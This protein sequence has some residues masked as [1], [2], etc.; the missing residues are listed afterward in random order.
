M[1]RPALVLTAGLGTR[2][3]P[4]TR[5]VAKPAVPVSGRTLIER[6]LDGLAHQGVHDVVLNLHHLPE[7]IT[8]IVGDG[9]QHGLRVRYSWESPVLGSAGGPRHALPLLAADEF[10]IVNG[11]TLCDVDLSALGAAHGASGADVT[12]AVVPNPA[13]DRYNALEVNEDDCVTGVVMKGSGRPGWHFVGLQIARASV[14]EALPDNVAAESVHG[15]YQGLLGNRGGIRVFKVSAPF[16]DVGT[17]LDYL[18]GAVALAGG[19]SAIEPDARVDS[20]ARVT[21]SIVWPAATVG[22]G[23]TLEDCI[24]TNVN[25]PAG[26]SARRAVLVPAEV[27]RIG[28]AA[29]EHAGL[30]VFDVS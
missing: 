28:D 1:N 13:P 5:L 17:P 7:T 8:G 24:V 20:S 3:D 15:L 19:R 4:I 18:E 16:I 26:F 22:A 21:R 11:D 9:A 30:L 25:V 29:R 27:R 10:F 14:F 2:L 23:A 12:L 6:V